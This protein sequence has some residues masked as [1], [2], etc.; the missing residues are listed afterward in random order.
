MHCDLPHSATALTSHSICPFSSGLYD[1]KEDFKRMVS[2]L[3]Q[4]EGGGPMN[5]LYYFAI[6]PE[7]FLDAAACVKVNII[8]TTS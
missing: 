5:R 1:S 7:V 6:P 2:I 3:E 8:Q 4:F